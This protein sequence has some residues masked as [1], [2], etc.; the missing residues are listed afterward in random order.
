MC[1]LGA[2]EHYALPAGLSS[3]GRLE[4]LYTDAW[5]PGHGLLNRTL[6]WLQPRLQDRFNPSLG[7]DNVTAYT[8]ALLAFEARARLSGARDSWPLMCARNEWFQDR[9]LATLEAELDTRRFPDD[10][11]IFCYSYAARRI[12]EFARA[13]GLITVLGQ[14]DPG[15]VEEELVAEHVARNPEL[16]PRWNRAPAGYWDD[17][18]EECRLADH[19]VVNSDWSREAIT[20]AGIDPDRISVIPLMYEPPGAQ[21]R[22]RRFPDRFTRE[23]PLRVLFL[24][25]LIIRKG[26]AATLEAVRL[27]KTEPVEFWFVG[28]EGVTLPGDLKASPNVHWVGPVRRGDVS[29]Y[30]GSCDLFLFPTLSDGFGLTQLEAMSHGLPVIASR[31]CGDV[32]VHDEHGLILQQA[33]AGDI[34]DAIRACLEDTERLG[35]WSGNVLNRIH[36]YSVNR[37]MPRLLGVC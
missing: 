26:I 32:V 10:T 31:H 19:I 7:N 36:D 23:R 30:Y 12:F 3:L 1:Q 17:W 18:R 27:L 22:A 24:G 34:V 25:S 11:V 8:G 15:P 14:I 4:R 28:H 9:V 5:L 29:R 35:R 6:G 37:V 16:V 33:D 2:R 21:G 13:H 20:E